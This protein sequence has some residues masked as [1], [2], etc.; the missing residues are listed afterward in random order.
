LLPHHDDTAARDLH[1]F[2]VKVVRV[3]NVFQL[4]GPTFPHDDT[5]V[6]V[7]KEHC[8]IRRARLIEPA[9]LI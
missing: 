3:G 4:C 9:S 1:R 2:V 5:I 7:R 8:R 6:C